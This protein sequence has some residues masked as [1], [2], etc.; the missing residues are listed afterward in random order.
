MVEPWSTGQPRF[1]GVRPANVSL[2]VVNGTFSQTRQ[3]RG[4]GLTKR[5]LG[6]ERQI[7]PSG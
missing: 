1:A 3:P 2:V 6:D 4:H 5:Y 7:W